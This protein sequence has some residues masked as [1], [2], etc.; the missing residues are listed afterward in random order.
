[1]LPVYSAPSSLFTWSKLR[2][3]QGYEVKLSGSVLGTLRG[4][5]LFSSTYEAITSEGVFRFQ[6]RG[7][8]GKKIEIIDCESERQV[9][10]FSPLGVTRAVSFLLPASTSSFSAKAVGD[11]TGI[12]MRKTARRFC[13]SISSKKRRKLRPTVLFRMHV[14][15]P[16]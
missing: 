16:C 1:M 14:F 6:S 7:W 3:I 5:K 2:R 12:F 9:A 15:S 11:L 4:T 13:H 8:C 10:F